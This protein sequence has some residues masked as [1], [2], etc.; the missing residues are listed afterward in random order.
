MIARSS[1]SCCIAK[2]SICSIHFSITNSSFDGTINQTRVLSVRRLCGYM[3]PSRAT[4]DPNFP[5]CVLVVRGAHP[6]VSFLCLTTKKTNCASY[7]STCFGQNHGV[8]YGGPYCTVLVIV[9]KCI[10]FSIFRQLGTYLFL[11]PTSDML[12][13]Y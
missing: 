6:F 10:D 7:V 11:N 2:S 13:R 8:T 4:V 12:D 3:S 1:Q 9:L 5:L